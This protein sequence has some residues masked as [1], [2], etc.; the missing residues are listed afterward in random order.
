[1]ETTIEAIVAYVEQL[2]DHKKESVLD[3]VKFISRENEADELDD[4]DYELAKRAENYDRT[5]TLSLE[6]V[7]EKFGMTDEDL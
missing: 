5:N 3:Y 6:E 7:L 1:M 2:S 4:F